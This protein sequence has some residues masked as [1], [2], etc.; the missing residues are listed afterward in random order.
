M[1]TWGDMLDRGRGIRE[2]KEDDYLSKMKSAG[3]YKPVF[4]PWWK[5]FD[6]TD[7]DIDKDVIKEINNFSWDKMWKKQNINDGYSRDL[8]S[9]LYK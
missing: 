6:S 9:K 7:I 4:V 2:R 1:S 8:L 3:V 5:N